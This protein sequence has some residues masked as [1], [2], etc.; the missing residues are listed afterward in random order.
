[1]LFFY[2][3]FIFPA[4]LS[5]W[6]VQLIFYS[7]VKGPLFITYCKCLITKDNKLAVTLFCR[8]KQAFLLKMWYNLGQQTAVSVQLIL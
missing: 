8:Q 6:L 4:S 5:K 3:E 1:M 2:L 7:L